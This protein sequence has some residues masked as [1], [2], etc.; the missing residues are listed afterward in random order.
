MEEA[1]SRFWRG[2]MVEGAEEEV[3]LGRGR[4]SVRGAAAKRMREVSFVFE[5]HVTAGWSRIR[6]RNRGGAKW[7]GGTP[8]DANFFLPG[9]TGQSWSTVK[10]RFLRK[11]KERNDEAGWTCAEVAKGRAQKE[12]TKDKPQARKRL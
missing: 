9:G 7:R 2:A 3:E 4:V 12:R 6:R 1:W 8:G 10:S 11:E 5:G